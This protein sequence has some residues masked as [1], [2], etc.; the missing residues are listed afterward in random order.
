MGALT[1]TVTQGTLPPISGVSARARAYLRGY[2]EMRPLR[3]LRHSPPSGKGVI[4]VRKTLGKMQI[5]EPRIFWT[6]R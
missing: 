2:R 4:E 1:P 3:H 6:A 5:G